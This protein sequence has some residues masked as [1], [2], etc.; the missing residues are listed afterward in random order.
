MEHSRVGAKF[1]D[2]F[3]GQHRLI[4]RSNVIGWQRERSCDLVNPLVGYIGDVL[5]QR[6]SYTQEHK[7]GALPKDQAS[8]AWASS[9][10]MIRRIFISNNAAVTSAAS[11]GVFLEQTPAKTFLEQKPAKTIFNEKLDQFLELRSNWDSYG[12]PPLKSET[13]DEAR[14]VLLAVVGMGLPLPWMAPGGDGSIGMQWEFGGEVLYL[15]VSP[16][17]PPAFLFSSTDESAAKYREGEL[18]FGNL[19]SVFSHYAEATGIP[20]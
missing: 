10:D 15:E 13:I 20:V 7:L 11:A 4:K 9:L 12:A 3:C 14:G 2:V 6:P 8:S 17:E 16:H 18:T 1:T 19:Y 5:A